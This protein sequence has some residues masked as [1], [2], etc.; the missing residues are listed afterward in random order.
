M[1]RSSEEKLYEFVKE[2]LQ[3]WSQVEGYPTDVMLLVGYRDTEEDDHYLMR[4]TTNPSGDPLAAWVQLGML[5]F[6]AE[7]LR[8]IGRSGF[9]DIQEEADGE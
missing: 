7:F 3:A 8:S 4:F 5:D 2:N 9:E 1:A 6:A